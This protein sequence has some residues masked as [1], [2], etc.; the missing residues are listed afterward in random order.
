MFTCKFIGK[1][2]YLQFLMSEIKTAKP[3][4]PSPLTAGMITNVRKRYQ[5][6]S[7]EQPV[8]ENLKQIMIK[9]KNKLHSTM[10]NDR[11]LV[12]AVS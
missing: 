2:E 4:I 5:Q 10:P 12:R 7:L 6:Y 11:C 9:I 8:S 3:R 1:L